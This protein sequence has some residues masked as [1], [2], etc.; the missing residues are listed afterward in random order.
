MKEI[1]FEF[2][3]TVPLLP[4]YS[5]CVYFPLGLKSVNG[6]RFAVNAS[7]ARLCEM[8]C[9]LLQHSFRGF[10]ALHAVQNKI[11]FLLVPQG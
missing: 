8:H 4:S 5:C 11:K 7:K 1:T 2:F 9:V 3:D 6:S 10:L